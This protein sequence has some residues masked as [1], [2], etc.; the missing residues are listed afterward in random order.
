MQKASPGGDRKQAFSP[1]P[2]E[3]VTGLG[4]LLGSCQ[5][6]PSTW[7]PDTLVAR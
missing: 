7:G 2:P 4:S 6:E 1:R 3:S 5:T